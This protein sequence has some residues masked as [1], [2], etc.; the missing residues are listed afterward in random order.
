MSDWKRWLVKS[1][2]FGAGS[3][4]VL[5]ILACI[6]FWYI[7]RPKPPKPWNRSAIKAAYYRVESKGD[8]V[9]FQYVLENTTT[10]DLRLTEADRPDV[11]VKIADT[12]SL[13]GFGSENV[14][15]LLPIYVPAKHRTRVAI[16]IS[17]YR[18]DATDPG[19]SATKE[20]RDNYHKK[21]V[22]QIGL[23]MP[24]LGGFEVFINSGRL[25]MICQRAGSETDHDAPGYPRQMRFDC[26]IEVSRK[27]P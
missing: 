17:G 6:S 26:P 9:D 14:K 18:L 24:N 3:A 15:L 13:F 8:A 25:E 16:E 23:K 27:T 2:G 19:V 12:N 4:L 5:A 22:E 21:V 11:G 20:E 1:L 10:E 7:S